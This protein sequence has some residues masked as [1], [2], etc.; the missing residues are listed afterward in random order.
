MKTDITLSCAAINKDG[1]ELVYQWIDASKKG[2]FNDLNTIILS[3]H[4]NTSP[5]DIVHEGNTFVINFKCP[6]V[7]QYYC[8]VS[9]KNKKEVV[10]QSR[11]VKVT[12]TPGEPI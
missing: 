1:K 4:S 2:V 12:A 10:V 8:Q 3:F 11:T 6:A 7:T 9:L 5:T